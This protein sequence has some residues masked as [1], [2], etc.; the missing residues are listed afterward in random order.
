MPTPKKR[1][2]PMPLTIEQSALVREI[3]QNVLEAL[4]DGGDGRFDAGDRIVVN[5]SVRDAS[6]LRGALKRL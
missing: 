4:R 3:V 6:I 1:T 5:L 2:Q